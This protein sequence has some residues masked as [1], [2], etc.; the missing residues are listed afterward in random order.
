MLNF[1]QAENPPSGINNEDEDTE[2]TAPAGQTVQLIDQNGL[3]GL[4]SQY[5]IFPCFSH[6]SLAT[7]LDQNNTSWKFTP[8]SRSQPPPTQSGTRPPRYRRFATR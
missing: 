3:E 1:F 5:K 7:L 6:N 4:N 2:C 8:M